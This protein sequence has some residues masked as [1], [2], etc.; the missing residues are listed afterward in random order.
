MNQAK[1]LGVVISADPHVTSRSAKA[2]VANNIGFL[3]GRLYRCNMEVKEQVLISYCRTLLLYF[4]VP[5]MVGEVWSGKVV[6]DLERQFHRKINRLPSDISGDAIVNISRQLQPAA[7]LAT[8]RAEKF[9]KM[10]MKQT[11]MTDML[12]KPSPLPTI[13]PPTQHNLHENRGYTYPGI[14]RIYFGPQQE[15]PQRST[16]ERSTIARITAQ[17]LT[18]S[19]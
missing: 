4:A 3:K 18:L 9:R 2:A 17:L 11:K 16:T 14:S 5:L 6:E 15:A 10:I 12:G 7:E 1:Y 19:T 8:R 13:P